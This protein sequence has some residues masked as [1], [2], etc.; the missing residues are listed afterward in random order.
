MQRRSFTFSAGASLLAGAPIFDCMAQTW[1]VKQPIRIVV[2]FAAGGVTDIVTRQVAEQMARQLPGATFVVENKPGAGGNLGATQVA[3]SDPDGYTLLAGTLSTY[4]LNAALYERLGHDPQK[5]LAL[6]GLT[7][8]VPIV[9]VVNPAL[10]VEDLK[11]F[12]ALLKANPDKYNYGS[13]G[14]GTSSHIALHLLLSMTGTKA[15]HV[16]YRGTAPALNDLLG[17]TVQFAVASPSV[18]QS[19]I[20]NRKLIALA[21]VSPTR[22]RSLPQ[23]P[24]MA[25][26]G[27]KDFDAYSWNGLFAPAATPRPIIDRLHR[28][29]VQALSDATL[30]AKLEEQGTLPMTAYAEIASAENYVK[31]E[32]AR[33]VP[34]VK[35][36]G[37]KAD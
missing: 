30:A 33:W 12:I 26:A 32:Y 2:P 25:E 29:T 36:L 34:Y 24:T 11:G 23:V 10:G 3:K 13:A 20:A 28:A 35:R 7:A 4:A 8:L 1:P 22:L 9:L 31:S 21:A 16:A 6:V 18:I 15:T 19:F 14:N 27:L 17:N 37:I 5:D